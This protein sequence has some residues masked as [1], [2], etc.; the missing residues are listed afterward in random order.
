MQRFLNDESGAITIDW[1]VLTAALTGIAI[2]TVAVIQP[3]FN[4]AADTMSAGLAYHDIP[5]H[6]VAALDA[7]AAAAQ[8]D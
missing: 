2:A 8:Q 5:P 3:G 4:G 6:L 1:V 7:K